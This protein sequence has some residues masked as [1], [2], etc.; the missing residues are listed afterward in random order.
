MPV[1]LVA[2]PIAAEGV[3]ILT[4]EGFEVRRLS[5]CDHTQLVAAV[6]EADGLLVRNALVD[7]EIIEA[8]PRLKVISRH[9]AGLETIDL[10][11]AT[12]RG[13]QVTYTPQANYLSVAEH[14]L[15]MMLV[16]AKNMLRADKA[17]RDGHFDFRHEHYGTELAGATLGIVGLGSIGT[18]LAR[19]ASLGLDMKVMA[20]DPYVETPPN[21]VEM[22]ED[23]DRLLKE[24]DFLS[25]NV[26]L[27]PQTE[28]LIGRE[29]LALMKPTAYVINCARSAV[30]VENDVIAALREGR[31][32]GAGVDVFSEDPPDPG[33][34][35]FTLEQTVLT[36]HM[37]A[38][39]TA[40]MSRMAIQAAQGIVEVLKERQVTWPA[41]HL[42]A[43]KQPV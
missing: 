11:A 9:G 7:R 10:G 17:I 29:Q 25:V 40:A 12:D 4:S 1:V 21:G 26:A 30:V 19:K 5:R 8:A 36:P 33:S 16:L 14:V 24:A 38:H 42:A 43:E 20:Y 18:A 6:E 39:T 32:A 2:Q 23:L 35:W 34:P 37:A 3:D 22:T 31:L 41:N 28:G 27:T 13:V 15:A